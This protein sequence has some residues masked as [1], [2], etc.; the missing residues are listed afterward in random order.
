MPL[1]ISDPAV[2]GAM[3]WLRAA[4]LDPG[5]LE[6]VSMTNGLQVVIG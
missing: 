1:L 5:A 2:L 4:F 3:A 6:G